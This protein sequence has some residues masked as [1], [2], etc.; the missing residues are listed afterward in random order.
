MTPNEMLRV[1]R[2]TNGWTHIRAAGEIGVRAD[3]FFQ[4]ESGKRR[5]N[6]NERR[7]FR[8]RIGI[9]EHLWRDNSD[10]VTPVEAGPANPCIV[11]YDGQDYSDADGKPFPSIVEASQFAKA[12]RWWGALILRANDRCKLRTMWP[13]PSRK[14]LDQINQAYPAGKPVGFETDTAWVA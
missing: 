9:P 14:Q 13:N 10:Y 5:P 6:R 8:I 4:I 11:Q 3:N 7:V 12:N 1:W 2:K